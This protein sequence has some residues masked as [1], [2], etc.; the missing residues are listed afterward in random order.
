MS[1]YVKLQQY[2]P[3]KCQKNKKNIKKKKLLFEKKKMRETR[4]T[5]KLFPWETGKQ[6]N[7]SSEN[8]RETRKQGNSDS[9][10][11][12]ETGKQEF[13]SKFGTLARLAQNKAQLAQNTA[14]LAQNTAQLGS[15]NASEKK[16]KDNVLYFEYFN[17]QSIIP[18]VTKID[19]S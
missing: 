12:R 7:S 4:E 16:Q 6:G 11:W 2:I 1:V 8:Q 14:Q 13:S 5:G 15:S 17:R 3:F 9:Q 18:K 19:W 10:N